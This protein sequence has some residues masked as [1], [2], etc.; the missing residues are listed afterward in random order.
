M[1]GHAIPEASL[2][3]SHGMTFL[4]DSVPFSTRIHRP[5]L[6][7]ASAFALGE[8]KMQDGVGTSNSDGPKP[9]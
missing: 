6:A 4:K 7:F 1:P 9:E 2:G 8:T 5:A 3:Q